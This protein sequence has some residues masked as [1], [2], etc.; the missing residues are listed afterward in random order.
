MWLLVPIVL[1]LTFSLIKPV[2]LPRYLVM[3]MPAVVLLASSGLC[4]LRPRWMT[5][6]ILAAMLGLSARGL[7]RYY[8][9][10]FDIAR[11]DW[12][13]A[14]QYLLSNS[15]PGDGVLFHSAQ[16]RLPFEYYADSQPG[17]RQINVLFPAYA[18][19][20]SYRDFLAN[21]KNA[22]LAEFSG[23][24]QRI[25]LVL[26]HNQLKDGEPDLTTRNIEDVLGRRYTLR[27]RI[28]LPG[29]IALLLYGS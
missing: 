14:T 19:K 25:W 12:R 2:F 29:S 10:D 13:G 3:C 5:I 26:A 22:P 28:N 20:L 9:A 24:Y 1:T 27:R 23:R 7:Q 6:L 8:R 15:L 21:A 4:R 11:E 18:D 16:A 17:R